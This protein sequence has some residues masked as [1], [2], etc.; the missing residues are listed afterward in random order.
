M[1]YS[2]F[3]LWKCKEKQFL[4]RI[5]VAALS[6]LQH[7]NKKCVSPFSTGRMCI[8]FMFNSCLS[9]PF[10]WKRLHWTF[11]TR[12][13]NVCN[14]TNASGSTCMM[15]VFCTD[16]ITKCFIFCWPCISLQIIVN[17]QPDA[18]FHVFI[19]S[20]HLS[21]CFEHHSA[22]HQEIELY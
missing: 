5:M 20:F 13:C 6:S 8:L 22:H 7:R 19:Y 21:T 15:H 9:F 1:F 10:G 17:N 16:K 12:K 11:F 3:R 14:S 18:L 2:I 4:L